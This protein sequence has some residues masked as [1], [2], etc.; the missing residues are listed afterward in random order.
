MNI[1]WTKLSVDIFRIEMNQPIKWMVDWSG[2]EVEGSE[3][4]QET[5]VFI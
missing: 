1:I 2:T 4:L 5:F 3:L